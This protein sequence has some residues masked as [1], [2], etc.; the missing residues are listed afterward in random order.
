MS[1]FHVTITGYT[2]PKGA[3]NISSVQWLMPP[4]SRKRPGKHLLV[5]F[6]RDFC[7]IGGTATMRKPVIEKS[8]VDGKLE[9]MP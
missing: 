3:W 4:Y 8:S 2:K 5:S 9:V 1:L 7:G 6:Y